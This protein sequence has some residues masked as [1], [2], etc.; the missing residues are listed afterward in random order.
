MNIL[1]EVIQYY[2]HQ[3][4]SNIYLTD[5]QWIN[6]FSNDKQYI[7]FFNTIKNIDFFNDIDDFDFDFSF[8]FED[9][10]VKPDIVNNCFIISI[11]YDIKRYKK[12]INE[13]RSKDIY[14]NFNVIDQFN[15]Y[16]FTKTLMK[17][18]PN[19]NYLKFLKKCNRIVKFK[20]YSSLQ[21]YILK[22]QLFFLNKHNINFLSDLYVINNNSYKLNNKLILTTLNKMYLYYIQR[23]QIDPH[24]LSY[25][26][27]N[28][29]KINNIYN[30]NYKII[31]NIFDFIYNNFILRSKDRNYHLYYS[32]ITIKKAY[33]LLNFS[34]E[35]KKILEDFIQK[36]KAQ[37]FLFSL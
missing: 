23:N 17:K 24:M 18:E 1:K 11:N 37:F 4:H 29:E 33:E 16:D 5:N 21:A 10:E 32:L 6:V 14:Y 20:I 8:G 12:I 19:N 13:L 31:N 28:C 34:S 7:N 22:Y 26:I 25:F 27:Q 15:I 36:A 9:K 2:Y 35:Q 30:F 3:Y